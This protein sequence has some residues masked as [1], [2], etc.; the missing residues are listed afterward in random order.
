MSSKER[1]RRYRQAH[2]EQCRARVRKYRLTHLKQ[3]KERCKK[4]IQK[5]KL[6][7]VQALGGKCQVCGYNKCIAALDV[8]HINGDRGGLP[9]KISVCRK[10]ILDYSKVVLLCRNC[11][12]ELH[13][14]E[15]N[16]GDLDGSCKVQSL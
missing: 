11:H 4:Y 2:P 3:C 13:Y 6:K 12:A 8:H 1:Q 7:H 14:N 9:R 15:K 5:N 16:R 10:A